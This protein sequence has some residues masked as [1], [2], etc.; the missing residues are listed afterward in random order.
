MSKKNLPDDFYDIYQ[1]RACLND[2]THNYC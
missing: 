1:Y 2:F